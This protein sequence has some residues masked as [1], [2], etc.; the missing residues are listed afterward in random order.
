MIKGIE[1]VREEVFQLIA[2]GLRK[3]ILTGSYRLI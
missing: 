3:T 1:Q 2:G